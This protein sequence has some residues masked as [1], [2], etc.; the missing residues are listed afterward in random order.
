MMLRGLGEPLPVHDLADRYAK[1]HTEK[2]Y[3]WEAG[4][5]TYR[6]TSPDGSVR[7]VKLTP[8]TGRLHDEALRTRWAAPFVR[9][10]EVVEFGSDGDHDWLMT[11]SLSG[12][13]AAT[14]PLRSAD[15]VA[16]VTAF[17]QGL[18]FFHDTVPVDEC[19]FWFSGLPADAD[20]VVCHGDYVLPNAFLTGDVVTGYID[21][22]D[23]G[24]AD[25]WLDLA[26]ALRSLEQP[27]NLGPGYADVFL[28]AYGVAADPAKAARYLA[29]YDAR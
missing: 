10:P 8:S 23:L 27:Y 1:W 9:V 14:H 22:G 17:A 13:D 6:L 16:L 3:E 25:R 2:V 4:R 15:P 24:V 19:P 18:R 28:S 29:L 21:L 12:V 20:L 26:V 5:P 7:Y 11:A